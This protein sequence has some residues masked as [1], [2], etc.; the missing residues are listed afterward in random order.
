MQVE[1]SPTTLASCAIVRVARSNPAITVAGLQDE[2][3][4]GAIDGW[5]DIVRRWNLNFSQW[6]GAMERAIAVLESNET[7]TQAQQEQQLIEAIKA[8]P[9]YQVFPGSQGGCVKIAI[10]RANSV[11]Q[12]TVWL[13]RK[14]TIPNLQR[15]LAA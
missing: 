5:S 2:L 7:A 3:E 15:I 11:S 6:S 9:G 1:L 10:T 4:R 12:R 13:G 8:K 14:S